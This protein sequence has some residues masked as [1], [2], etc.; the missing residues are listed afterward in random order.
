M[1]SIL[2][3]LVT[4]PPLNLILEPTNGPHTQ[5]DPLREA[6]VRLKLLDKGAAQ[7]RDCADF[8]Q[9]QDA[10]FGSNSTLHE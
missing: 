6:P 8:G 5:L 2:R 4:Q 3:N 1:L 10:Q 7:A 9:A